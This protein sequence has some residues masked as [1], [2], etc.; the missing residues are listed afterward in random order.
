MHKEKSN[1]ICLHLSEAPQKMLCTIVVR[2]SAFVCFYS[3]E[4]KQSKF[5]Y[6]TNIKNLQWQTSRGGGQ[7][8]R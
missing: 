6:Q 2:M 5:K 1:R 7:V 8:L 4:Q 3:H